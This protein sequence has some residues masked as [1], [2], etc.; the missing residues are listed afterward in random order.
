[1]GYIGFAWHVRRFGNI[2]NGYDLYRV[3]ESY[4]YNSSNAGNPNDAWHIRTGG[5][6][7]HISNV[8]YWFYSI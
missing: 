2:E 4:G 8:D 6:V 1:M 7:Y 3:D 5:D